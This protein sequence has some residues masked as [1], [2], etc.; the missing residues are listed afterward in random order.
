MTEPAHAHEIEIQPPNQA[1]SFLA[2]LA[3]QK[4]GALVSEMS[5]EMRNLVEAIETHFDKFRGTVSGTLALNIKFTLDPK[6]SAY[7]V[8]TEYAVRMPKVPA[9]STI[10]W[11]GKDG[12]LAATNP[13]QLN[14]PFA[15]VKGE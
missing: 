8:E 4:G 11:L 6:L 1:K 10:M 9:A 14:L 3:E 5:E 15:Q 13:A 7:R 2:F 12:N